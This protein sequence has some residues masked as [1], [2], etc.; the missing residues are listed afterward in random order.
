MGPHWF[1]PICCVGLLTGATFY[2]GRKAYHTI[3]VGSAAIC[4]L[5]YITALVSLFIVSC[6]D[7]GLVKADSRYEGVPSS[8]VSAGRGWRY[9]DLCS[10]YQP[11]GAVHCP[12]C[13]VCIEGYDH[14]CPWMGTCIGKKNFTSF[15]TFNLTWLFYFL[16]AIIWV[17]FVGAA[18]YDPYTR[19]DS[20]S[21]D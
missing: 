19:T 2:F 11:P 3:G 1:G 7:P 21:D 18:F 14:H 13:N 12:D 17:S 8:D 15:M 6:S 9:C 20:T 4:L 16:Y 10:I 5:F